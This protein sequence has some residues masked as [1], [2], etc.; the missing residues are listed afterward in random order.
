MIRKQQNTTNNSPF[1]KGWQSQS[2]GVLITPSQP[3]IQ[4]PN[5]EYL[6][7]NQFKWN[8]KISLPYNPKLK[9]R[10]RELRKQGILSEVIFWQL[11]KGKQLC[12][13]DFT[14]QQIIGHY[15]V[16]FFCNQFRLVIEIDGNSHD[17]KQEYDSV[18]DK[19]LENLGLRCIH[20]EDKEVLNNLEGI[21]E[22][23]NQYIKSLYNTTNTPPTS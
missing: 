13:L 23:L 8:T 5:Q 17:S 19:F 18:R 20:F 7:Q 9:D 16:D 22:Y 21:V 14:R 3:N 11:V 15:I 10:A 6:K 12:N 4:L 1:P 2:D